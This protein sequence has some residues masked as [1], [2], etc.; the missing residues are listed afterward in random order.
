MFGSV[1]GASPATDGWRCPR[2]RGTMD[3]LAVRINSFLEQEGWS[4]ALVGPA[5]AAVER[6]AEQARSFQRTRQSAVEF[7]SGRAELD[8]AQVLATLSNFGWDD[9]Q[10]RLL[11]HQQRGLIH[12]LTAVNAA[13]FS[14][15]GSGKTATN[16]CCCGGPPPSK[17]HRSHHS[18]RTTIL[19][20]TLGNRSR[21]CLT[22]VS[23]PHQ[24][25][26][27]AGSS[28]ANFTNPPS[29]AKS[30]FLVTRRLPQIV[31]G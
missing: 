2:R 9:D 31:P 19:F 21:C 16:T 7:R 28:A 14:V 22:Q 3:D 25:F 23:Y 27:A 18:R 20:R 4:V 30:Y 17:H 5:S 12:G 10:R 29:H 15:P 24:G 6:A 26:A 8:L 11:D 13:N 1:L